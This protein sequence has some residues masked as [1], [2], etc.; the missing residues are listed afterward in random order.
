MLSEVGR[1]TTVDGGQ[2]AA[3]RQSVAPPQ[4][5]AQRDELSAALAACRGAFFSIGL[6]SGVINLLM[7][8]GSFYMLEVYDRVLPSRSLPTLAGL[9]ILAAGLFAFLGLLDLIRGRVLAR[10]ATSIDH[11]LTGRVY[12][13]FVRLPLKLGNRDLDRVREFLSSQGPLALFD[14]PWIPIYLLV[15]FAFHVWI[16]IA[17]LSGAIVLIGLTLVTEHF[18]RA[19]TLA[20]SRLA[21]ARNGLA[22]TSRRNAEAIAAMGMAARL[23]ERWGEANTEFV[24]SHRRASDVTG[25]LAA[26]A[27]VFRMM[28]Q[29][30][31]LGIGGY[32]VIQQQATAG[33][34]IAS[35]IVTA[36]ALAPIDLAIGNWRGF[37]GAR[38]A[39]NRL[40]QLLALLPAAADP[41]PL[42]P[43]I[44]SLAVEMASTAPPRGQKLV[45]QDANFVLKAGNGLGVIGPSASGKS[46]LARMLVGI[47]PSARGIIR[48][49]GAALPHWSPEALGAHVG[50]LPQDVEL[51]AGTVAQNICRFERSPDPAAILAA[52]KAA[53][54]HDL[55]LGLPDAYD[56]QIGDQGSTLSAGQRQRIALAR[57]LYR[58]PFLVVLDEPNSN[59][60]AAGEAA[61]T[62]AIL[63]VRARGGIAVV[64]AH[65]PSA[66]AGVDFLLVMSQGRQRAFGPKT[67][68]LRE[69]QRATTPPPAVQPT[70]MKVGEVA[71]V[72]S[73]QPAPART[74]LAG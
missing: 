16:G 28:L 55:I 58:D 41:L 26:F 36:R 2:G 40:G 53:G 49:D 4:S 72:A 51:M 8:T 12:D 24:A 70:P 56:T 29:S 31:V 34:I 43:P 54:V 9:T 71:V 3:R 68:I 74:S 64:V 13:S 15:C 44:Q 39:W 65:Q 21:A 50:Y 60:D 37:V 7:L 48:L 27:K 63:G 1:Q 10:I 62:S 20:A 19:P 6:F 35:S 61:L 69:L 14:L 18:T 32:L 17:A 57:A 66:L 42:P 22:E 45:V 33:V 46:S 67:E 73:L 52:A 30:G 38:Q 25:G 23:R 11:A 47:W 59:L 5:S